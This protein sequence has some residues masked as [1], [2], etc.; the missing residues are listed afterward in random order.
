VCTLAVYT[1]VW[2]DL[3][4]VIAANRDEF[5]ERPTRGPGPLGRGRAFGGRDLQAGGSWLAL[6]VDGLAVGVLNRRTD[7]AADPSLRSRGE[8]CVRLAEEASTEAALASLCAEDPAAYNPFNLL[9]AD[10]DAAWVAQNR[11]GGMY[12]RALP[13][14]LHLLTNLDLNDPTCQRISRST[15]RFAAMIERYADRGNRESLV[16]SLREILAD[17][18]LPLDDRRPTDQLCIHMDGYGTRSSSVVWIDRDG[19]PRFL[20]ADGPPCEN[21]FRDRML[22]FGSVPEGR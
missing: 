9:L 22:S 6:G 8:L 5:H 13:R 18:L 1:G 14:G 7:K 10:R 3:P 2:S 16:A 11:E 17:H 20:H 12:V 21:E 19:T 15:H 4:L